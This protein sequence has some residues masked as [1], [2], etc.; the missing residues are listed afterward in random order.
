MAGGEGLIG[1]QLVDRQLVAAA[2]FGE[3]L[4]AD[5]VF[6][7]LVDVHAQLAVVGVPV[8]RLELD[9]LTLFPYRRS[10]L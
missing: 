6:G 8:R 7:G 10:D 2:V 3:G 4:H 1:V 9:L 5:D